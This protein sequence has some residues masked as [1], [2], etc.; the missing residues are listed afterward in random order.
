[1]VIPIPI[2]V[3]QWRCPHCDKILNSRIYFRPPK[4]S[5]F[6]CSRCKQT[7]NCSRDVVV[8]SW[9]MATI[10]RSLPV[11]WALLVLY[12]LALMFIFPGRMPKDAIFAAAILGWVPCIIPAVITGWTYGTYVGRSHAKRLNLS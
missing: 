2:R 11:Y 5:T 12:V 1:M 9:R 4:E 7:I 8:T 3:R 10:A 6:S